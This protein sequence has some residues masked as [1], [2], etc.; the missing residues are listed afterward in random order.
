[1]RLKRAEMFTVG[2][3]VLCLSDISGRPTEMK[4]GHVIKIVGPDKV[5]VEFYEYI[6][7]HTCDRLGR[8][9]CCLWVSTNEL[10][11]TGKVEDT[12]ECLPQSDFEA[13]L[14]C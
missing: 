7:G 13:I 8:D 11:K 12:W 4:Y 9:G 6:R 2:D 5:G 10:E 14:F 1:M 3:E